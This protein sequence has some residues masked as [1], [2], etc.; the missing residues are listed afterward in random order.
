MKILRYFNYR[1]FP[2]G[3][4]RIREELSS[5]GSAGDEIKNREA[6]DKN[7]RVGMSA[8]VL[9]K[10]L[11]VTHFSEQECSEYP[12]IGSSPDGIVSSDLLIEVKCPYVSWDK[13]IT[14]KT[15]P[16]LR[17]ED[18]ELTLS[19]TH[20]YYYQIQGQLYC[21]KRKYC[22]FIIY[23]KQDSLVIR[24]EKD[25]KFISSMLVK[26]EEFFY[27]YFKNA[28]LNKFYFRNYDKFDFI[29]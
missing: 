15:V 2:D 1:E 11:K 19:K 14:V 28:L 5:Y 8:D 22:D 29:H 17:E 12:Y 10:F 25:D 9:L 4:H 16:Y 23:T 24:I 20:D 26:L 13:P 27:C 21:S 6:P 3:N 18:G 7:G